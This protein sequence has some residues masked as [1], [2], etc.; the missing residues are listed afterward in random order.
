MLLDLELNQD[1]WHVVGVRS[2]P[3]SAG[4]LPFV[5]A[6]FNEEVSVRFSLHRFPKLIS[7]DDDPHAWTGLGN[8]GRRLARREFY[9]KAEEH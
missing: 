3:C 4:R 9:T 8:W 7:C 2:D 5:V 1:E 6:R